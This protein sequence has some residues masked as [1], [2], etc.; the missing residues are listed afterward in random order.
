MHDFAG[1]LVQ[2]CSPENFQEVSHSPVVAQGE[3]YYLRSVT[4]GALAGKQ[5]SDL[6]TLF[7][8]LA[9]SINLNKG[10]C[11]APQAVAILYAMR[12]VCVIG[13]ISSYAKS[14]NAKQK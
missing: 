12:M 3:R 2:R 13:M 11:P 5:A 14:T 10:A 4:R 7:P 9:Q 8:L 6:H 1:E